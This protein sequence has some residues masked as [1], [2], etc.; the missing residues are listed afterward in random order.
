MAWRCFAGVK[1]F[2]AADERTAYRAAVALLEANRIAVE[3]GANRERGCSIISP[4][5]FR[6]LACARGSRTG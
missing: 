5:G 2:A 1:A 3:L 4:A 6:K